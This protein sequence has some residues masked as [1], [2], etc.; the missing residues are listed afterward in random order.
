MKS[1][2]HKKFILTANLGLMFVFD[3]QTG[4]QLAQIQL[5]HK[6]VSFFDACSDV[7]IMCA[8]SSVYSY[9]LSQPTE[10]DFI[11]EQQNTKD[12][13]YIPTKMICVRNRAFLLDNTRLAQIDPV[14]FE[15]SFDQINFDV[16]ECVYFSKNLI[17]R[18]NEKLFSYNLKER[19][20]REVFTT[21]MNI[22]RI[23]SSKDFVLVSTETQNFVFNDT[24]DIVYQLKSSLPADQ[25][26]IFQQL[27]TT[28]YLL[29]R[30][31]TAEIFEAKT[32]LKDKKQ[33]VNSSCT[34]RLQ[35]QIL[36]IQIQIESSTLKCTLIQKSELIPIIQNISQS[37]KDSTEINQQ[38]Q[39]MVQ[40]QQITAQVSKSQIELNR[41]QFIAETVN[42]QINVL[43]QAIRVEDMTAIKGLIKEKQFSLYENL[44][45]SLKRYFVQYLLNN[46]TASAMRWLSYFEKDP[47]VNEKKDEIYIKLQSMKEL[48]KNIKQICKNEI[49]TS[50][51][52]LEPENVIEG[53]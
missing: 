6:E 20:T 28:V 33:L 46:M 35:N 49:V 16:S 4:S 41:K 36:D 29:A 31:T 14:S 45:N 8:G 18:T 12:L 3:K 5:K 15:T 48:M 13:E 47:T 53:W 24:F 42:Q 34:M 2:F 30:G 17:Y 1:I 25:L 43:E 9:K 22:E 37:L 27:N 32:T 7:I 52:E 40:V 10:T 21:N 44:P 11:L 50:I 38:N 51:G 26:F 39:Q 19:K 23:Q